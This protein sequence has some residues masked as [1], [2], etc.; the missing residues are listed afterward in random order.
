MK[1][2]L[3][4]VW[5]IIWNPIMNLIGAITAL[6]FICMGYKPK[7]YYHGIYFLKPGNWGGI[8]LGNFF[9][10]C[11][12]TKDYIEHEYGHV[13][14]S[15]TLGPIMPILSLISLIRCWY[16]NNHETTWKYDDWWFE[17]CATYLGAINEV[18][19][20]RKQ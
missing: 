8:S 9:F 3:F 18:K 10:V 12:E 14:E 7:R 20:Q 15:I 4:W 5:T 1:N 16:Y 2:F 13:L 17:G 6:V 19:A 11:V